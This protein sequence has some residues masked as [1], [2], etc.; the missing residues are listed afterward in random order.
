[1]I[2]ARCAGAPR[3]PDLRSGVPHLRGATAHLRVQ[4]AARA[5]AAATATTTARRPRSGAEA[6]AA[7]AVH[8]Q[9]RSVRKH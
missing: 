2:I 5:A 7:A 9:E 1:M 4:V 6:G 3:P 8:Q